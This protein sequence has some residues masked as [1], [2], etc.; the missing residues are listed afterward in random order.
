MVRVEAQERLPQYDVGSGVNTPTTPNPG[1]TCHMPHRMLQGCT[2][3]VLESWGCGMCRAGSSGAGWVGGQTGRLSSGCWDLVNWLNISKD[4]YR[5]FDFPF[6]KQLQLT[7]TL[8]VLYVLYR[9]VTGEMPLERCS[10]W[11]WS[12][13][14]S[15]WWT[16]SL[17]GWAVPPWNIC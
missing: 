7:E 10:T 2:K 14:L 5:L 8:I 9:K 17:S 11:T 13:Y 6:L 16:W 12:L 3:D 1:P 15:D 4:D